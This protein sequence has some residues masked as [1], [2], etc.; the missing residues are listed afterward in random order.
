MLKKYL[1]TALIGSALL[2]PV[3]FAETPTTATPNGTNAAQ[4]NTTNA[5]YRG[6]WRASKIV[7]LNVYNNSNEKVG[8]IDDLLTDK[9]GTVKGVVIGVG[10]FL[11]MGEHLVAISFDKI[12]FVDEPVSVGLRVEHTRSP[13][14]TATVRLRPRRRAR[15]PQTTTTTSATP[16]SAEVSTG[17]RITPCSTPPRTS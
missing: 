6:E 13:T 17:I 3:A 15:R 8:S 14:T 9:N 16:A 4:M 11:G 5:S 12:K 7:G 1:A 10:G 2:A